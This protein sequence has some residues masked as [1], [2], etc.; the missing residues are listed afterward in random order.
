MLQQFASPL[1]YLLL[2]ALLFDMGHWLIEEAHNIPVESLAIAAVLV[3]D[4]LLGVLQE[5][6][7]EKALAELQILAAQRARV[8]RE[9]V[10]IDLPATNVVPGDVMELRA[11]GRVPADGK[12]LTASRTMVDTSRLT[13]ESL[14]QACEIGDEILA[15]TMLMRGHTRVEVTCTGT[16]SAMGQLSHML[17]DVGVGKTPLE[18]R[19]HRLKTHI[20]WVV[21]GLALALVFPVLGYVAVATR[22]ALFLFE[23]ASQVAFV[24]P[25]RRLRHGSARSWLV[26]VV[27]ASGVALQLLTLIVS[28]LRRVLLLAPLDG[29]A[30]VWCGA[31]TIATLLVAELINAALMRM[32]RHAHPPECTS[33]L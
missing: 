31:I 32:P 22:T 24:Y 2:A 15:G 33:I 25:A 21:G 7:A 17:Q 6:R 20:A 29:R 8:W 27:V 9:G 3:V 5:H 14:A 30:F 12:V 13:G 11:G 18:Q 19:L 16:Q 4:A 23:P 28:G 1:V 10:L 26:H